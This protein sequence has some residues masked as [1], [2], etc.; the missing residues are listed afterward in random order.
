MTGDGLMRADSIESTELDNLVL[1]EDPVNPDWILAGTPVARSVQWS[2]STDR[3]TTTHV[4]DCTA[5]RFRWF[6][7][8][9][10]IVHI[11]EGSVVVT[12]GNRSSRTLRAGDAALF[13][14]GSWFEW[15]VQEYVRKHAILRT[16]LPAP[17][18]F[19]MRVLGF[20]KRAFARG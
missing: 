9:D 16:P 5:G 20:L 7:A 6:F 19:T 11:I 10:E 1:L 8:V 17:I 15:E 12:D 13:R 4:W 2:Q 18:A 3:T 14:A